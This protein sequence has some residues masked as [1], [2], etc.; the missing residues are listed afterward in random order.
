MGT[1]TT[2]DDVSIPITLKKNGAV[3]SI[4]S[5]A[6]VKGKLCNNYRKSLM[7]A[8]TLN[9]S[10]PDADLAN[11]LVIFELSETDTSSITWGGSGTIEIEVDDGG[12]ST[13]WIPVTIRVGTI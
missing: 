6:V 12:K 3:F 4:D 13:F 11:S 9:N 5:G 7:S 1:I 8:V 2:G 10:H